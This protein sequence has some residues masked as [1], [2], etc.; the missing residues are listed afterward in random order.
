MTSRSYCFTHNTI[1]QDDFA[2]ADFTAFMDV[3]GGISGMRYAIGQ[4]EQGEQGHKHIQGYIEFDSPKSGIARS[5]RGAS[6]EC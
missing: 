5:M 6:P 2:E 4:L 1:S 3:I